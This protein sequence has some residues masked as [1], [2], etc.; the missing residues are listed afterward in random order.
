MVSTT[1]RLAND[2]AIAGVVYV[3]WDANAAAFKAI[4]KVNVMAAKALLAANLL[5]VDFAYDPGRVVAKV[6]EN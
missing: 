4:W 3:L 5:A 6:L 2:I 1:E